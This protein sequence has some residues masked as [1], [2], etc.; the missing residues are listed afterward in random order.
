MMSNFT[1]QEFN[2]AMAELVEAD[3]FLNKETGKLC[4]PLS[5]L[6]FDPYTNLNQLMP[7]AWEYGIFMQ[8]FGLDIYEAIYF[9][10]GIS[11]DWIEGID[12]DPVE[13]IRQCLWMVWESKK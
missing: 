10:D 6:E 4:Y 11:D 3:T 5:D 2:L 12:K 13:A 9:D 1:E 7:I 8:P